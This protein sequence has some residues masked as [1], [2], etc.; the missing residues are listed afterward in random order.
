MC[1]ALD[2]VLHRVKCSHS[3]FTTILRNRHQYY[4]HFTDEEDETQGC[5][6]S[7]SVFQG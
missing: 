2:Y 1:Q 6:P 4:P 5:L 7:Y 3:P